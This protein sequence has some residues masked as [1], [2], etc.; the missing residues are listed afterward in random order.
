MSDE[1]VMRSGDASESVL[2]SY[3]ENMA[4]SIDNDIDRKIFEEI[5][6]NYDKEFEQYGQLIAMEL[7]NRILEP[8]IWR[9]N[10]VLS[11]DCLL[12]ATG[13]TRL[14]PESM[15]KIAE[16]RGVTKQAVS[17]EVTFWRDKF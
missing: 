14:R 6:H 11:L 7:L 17:K 13:F 15:D 10:P 5:I 2:A 4:A 9:D 3:W 1:R 8:L 12:I 16:K